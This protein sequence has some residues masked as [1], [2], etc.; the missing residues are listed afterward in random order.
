MTDVIN[1]TAAF[2]VTEMSQ[3]AAARRAALLL[4]QRSGFSESRSGQVELVVSELAT[5]LARHARSGEMLFRRIGDERI[6]HD[7]V[8][9][10]ILAIDA[11]PGMPDIAL[12]RRDGH[13]TAGTLGQGLGAIE[14]QSHA[15]EIDTRPAGTVA[16][17]RIWR[18]APPGRAGQP[19]FEAGAVHVSKAGEAICGD[20]WAC[21]IREDRVAVMVADGLGHGLAAHD[22]AHLAVQI[23][24][25]SVDESPLHIVTDLHA[26]L[27]STRG[28]AVAVAVIDVA[29]GILRCSGLGNISSAIV[30]A[31]GE[32]R[33][34][35]SQNGTAGHTAPRI[36]EFAYP[37]PRGSFVVMHSDGVGM[38]WDVA[39]HAGLSN[40]HP[41]VIAGA[42]YRQASRRRDDATVVIV[43]ERTPA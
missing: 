43:K 34:L 29:R 5:N 26:G 38:Q 24:E 41:S 8:G 21:R 7:P 39:A 33:S 11:G 20:D 25:R 19:L 32:R 30:T 18:D 16:L 36:Q 14:R 40:R 6:K 42:L 10:E 4:A 13:S 2:Q 15:F 35:V 27:R 17:A 9:V 23:F 12:F 28:A 31:S 3:V 1:T 22:A 37:M